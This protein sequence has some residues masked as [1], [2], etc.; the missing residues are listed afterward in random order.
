MELTA[1]NV[2]KVFKACLFNDGEDTTNH[3]AAPGITVNIGFH[4]ERLK[5]HDQNIKL[6]LDQL[7]HQFRES[8]EA[9][10]W[11][12]LN[13]CNR[14]DGEQWTGVHRTMEQLMLLGA[15]AGR[16]SVMPRMLWPMLPGGV[17]YF[18]I[19]NKD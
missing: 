5:N 6:L 13:A 8:T 3:V 7:P 14:E 18:T 15:A 17:P 12:F 10:G 9:G 19:L 16:V 2:E 4:P 1:E 11:S